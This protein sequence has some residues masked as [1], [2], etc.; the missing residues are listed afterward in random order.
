MAR[1]WIGIAFLGAMNLFSATAI[2]FGVPAVSSPA[3]SELPQPWVNPV[4]AVSAGESRFEQ[5]VRTVVRREMD[6]GGFFVETSTF[7]AFPP[8]TLSLA[9]TQVHSDNGSRRRYEIAPPPKPGMPA[10]LTPFGV[11]PTGF[12]GLG[13]MFLGLCALITV[14]AITAFIAPMRLRTL[15]QSLYFSWRNLGLLTLVGLLGYGFSLLLVF[16]LMTMVTAIPFAAVVVLMV[17]A[18][19]LFGFVSVIFALGR[20]LRTKLA[21]SLPSPVLDIVLGMALVFPLGLLPV[22]G[23]PIILTLTSLGFGAFLMTK[24]GSGEPWSLLPLQE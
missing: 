5:R 4:L 21:L 1:S 3:E 23:W 16:I 20:W 8:A 14:G 19:T 2:A 24:A 10:V 22:A 7:R 18:A 6:Q 15:Q 17:A 12:N 11:Y 9:R 13:M